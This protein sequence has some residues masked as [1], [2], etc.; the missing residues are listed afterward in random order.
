MKVAFDAECLNSYRTGIGHYAYNLVKALQALDDAPEMALFIGGAW[1]DHLP[2]EYVHPALRPWYMRAMTRL[3]RRLG[4][5]AAKL[6]KLGNEYYASHAYRRSV[7][8]V[9]PSL[10]HGPNYRCFPGAAP[11]VV[12]V[13]DVSCFRHPETHPVE[14]V[15][16]QRRTLPETLQRVEH[17]LTVSAFSKAEIVACLGVAPDRITVTHNAADAGFRPRGATQVAASL[18][19]YRLEYGHYLLT[20]GTLEPRK[21]LLTVL[22]AYRRLPEK[23]RTRFPLV[24]VGMRGWQ[25]GDLMRELAPLLRA[26]QVRVTGYVPQ[27]VLRDLYSGAK[28]FLFPSLYEGFGMPALE[29]LASGIPVAVAN[30]S[31]LPEVVGEAGL[32]VDALDID[33]WVQAIDSL[34]QD[35]GAGQ[36]ALLEQAAR[37][38]WEE[39]ARKTL[40]VYRS[41]A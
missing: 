39:C 19:T 4:P 36:R 12:T 26:G 22:H 20:V 14:R 41:L 11:A 21:N 32:L 7:A 37:F 10:F 3:S 13:H 24:V 38:S 16:W 29:A 31:A 34:L 25:E 40:I 15:W 27:A 18:L 35:T 5:G 30:A 17:V 6:R 9:G 33:A 2:G 28:G 1:L 23:V 8:R